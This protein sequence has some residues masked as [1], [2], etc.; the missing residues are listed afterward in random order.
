MI[1]SNVTQEI[2]INKSCFDIFPELESER[3]IYR[4]VTPEDVEDIFKIYSDPKVAKYDWY[5]PMATKEDALSKINQYKEEFQNKEEITWGIARKNDDKIIGYCCLFDFDDN[6]RRSEIG[7]G[8]NR[9]E[10]NK[11]YATEAIK[12]LVKFGFEVMNLNRVEATVTLGNDASVKALKKA[13]FLQEGIVR[14]RSIMKGK[15]EDD[16]ILAIIKKDYKL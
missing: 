12:I 8:F 13:N 16:V 14:E 7:Y 1:N 15:F 3:V 4:E 2:K 10:W 9:D 11:G 6:S 5:K